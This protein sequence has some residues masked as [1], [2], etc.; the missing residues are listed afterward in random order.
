MSRKCYIHIIIGTEILVV[1][2]GRVIQWFIGTVIQR[3]MD[4][5]WCSD[6]MGMGDHHIS[7][8]VNRSSDH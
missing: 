6:A 5:D 8:M 4:D 2:N 1:I 7:S 3:L